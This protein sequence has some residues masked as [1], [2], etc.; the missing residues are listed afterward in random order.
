MPRVKVKDRASRY[1]ARS[2]TQRAV[3][4]PAHITVYMVLGGGKALDYIGS[5]MDIYKTW[6][7]DGDGPNAVAHWQVLKSELGQDLCSSVELPLCMLED[8]TLIE[9]TCH[10]LL[11]SGGIMNF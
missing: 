4:T 1:A 10:D 7:I 3:Y 2:G 9:A 11:N 5:L 8:L 6:R